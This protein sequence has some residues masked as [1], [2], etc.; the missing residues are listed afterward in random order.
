MTQSETL[1]RLARAM[2]AAPTVADPVA[3]RAAALLAR[4]ALEHDV[5][6]RLADDLPGSQ[7]GTFRAQLL[8]LRSLDPVTGADGAQLHG[9]LSHACHHHPYELGPTVDE[10]RGFVERAM[11]VTARLTDTSA[12]AAH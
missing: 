8:C 3:V 11:R 5:A 1:L 7:H 4:R 12:Q 10:A 9:E 2:L 6:A